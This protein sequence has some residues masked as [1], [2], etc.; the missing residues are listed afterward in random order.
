MRCRQGILVGCSSVTGAAETGSQGPVF[1]SFSGLEKVAVAIIFNVQ[2][3]ASLE[4][5]AALNRLEKALIE[6]ISGQIWIDRES[7]ELDEL[8]ELD[9]SGNLMF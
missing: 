7:D 1:Q 3:R 4:D 6:A 8:D 2:K 5:F 9:E